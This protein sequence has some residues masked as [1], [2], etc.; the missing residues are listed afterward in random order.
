M[1]MRRFGRL[2]AR[3]HY[4]EEGAVSLETVLILGAIALPVL[5]FLIRYGWPTVRSY[6]ERGLTDLQ[7]ASDSAKDSGTTTMTGGDVTT[8]ASV[9]TEPV[10][11]PAP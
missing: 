2:L 9:G 3:V 11:E 7:A 8:D 1:N 6:F 5:I 4:S 10:A